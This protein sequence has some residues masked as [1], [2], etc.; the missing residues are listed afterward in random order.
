VPYGFSGVVLAAK[1]DD[2]VLHTAYG[3]SDRRRGIPLATDFAFYI[4]S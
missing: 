4:G 2:V 1:G 3:V